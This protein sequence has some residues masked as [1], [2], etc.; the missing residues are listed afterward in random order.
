MDYSSNDTNK[1]FMMTP[2]VKFYLVHL[3]TAGYEYRKTTE[4]LRW[5]NVNSCQPVPEVVMLPTSGSI[6]SVKIRNIKN[7]LKFANG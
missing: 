6:L 3:V 7:I 2:R 1:Y 4:K 5:I